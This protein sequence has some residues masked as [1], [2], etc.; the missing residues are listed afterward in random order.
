MRR[1]RKVPTKNAGERIEIR[2]QTTYN[3]AV[4][5]EMSI[6]QDIVDKKQKFIN[7]FN[8]FGELMFSTGISSTDVSAVKH[9]INFKL[10]AKA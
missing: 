5:Q 4:T 6:L 10:Q 8:D 1:T 9:A 3:W 7:I 2:W